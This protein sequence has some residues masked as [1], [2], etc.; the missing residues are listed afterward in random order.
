MLELIE[1]SKNQVPAVDVD[2]V[3]NSIDEDKAKEIMA[4]PKILEAM[5]KE[6]LQTVEKN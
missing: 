1:S 6:K 5:F 4:D 3:V 2:S